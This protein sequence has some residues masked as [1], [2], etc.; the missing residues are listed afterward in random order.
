MEFFSPFLMEF[1][2][3]Q[4]ISFRFL[5]ALSSSHLRGLTPETYPG[6]VRDLMTFVA[7]NLPGREVK[8]STVEALKFG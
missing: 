1:L 8:V 4:R 7:N 5:Y 6:M 2:G 3:R